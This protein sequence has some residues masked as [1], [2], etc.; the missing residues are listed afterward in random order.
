MK[1]AGGKH[2]WEADELA[3]HFTLHPTDWDLIANKTDETRLGFAILLKYFQY[4]G[5]FP[6]QVADVPPALVAFLAQQVDVPAVAFA[7]YAWQNWNATNDFIFYGKGREFG[8]NKQEDMEVAMLCLHLVQ[9]SMVYINTL[10][11]QDLLSEPEWKE[12]LTAWFRS[13]I[14]EQVFCSYSV[15]TEQGPGLLIRTARHQYDMT[16]R[17]KIE[18]TTGRLVEM[19]S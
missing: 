2:G 16:F 15:D 10:L 11:I 19:M 13:Q 6:K 14:H 12:K 9:I 17:T 8:T 7:A 3:E 4:E 5:T 18:K 1:G